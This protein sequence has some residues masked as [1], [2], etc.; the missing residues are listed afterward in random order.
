MKKYKVLFSGDIMWDKDFKSFTLLP[1]VAIVFQKES[2][3]I[4]VGWLSFFCMV[5][6]EKNKK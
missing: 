5:A 1:V 3:E 6:F 4:L 2:K